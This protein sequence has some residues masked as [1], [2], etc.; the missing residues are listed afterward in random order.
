MILVTL[1]DEDIERLMTKSKYQGESIIMP[2]RKETKHS[3]ICTS[4]YF[5]Y[6]IEFYQS[7]CFCAWHATKN[8][9]M[10]MRAALDLVNVPIIVLQISPPH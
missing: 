8:V 9:F 2:K 1:I 3:A 5:L 6:V 10:Q 7:D 4:R